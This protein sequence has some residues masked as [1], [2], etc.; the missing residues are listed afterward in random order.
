MSFWTREEHRTVFSDAEDLTYP[1]VYSPWTKWFTGC[2]VPGVMAAYAI[3]A[4]CRGVI[5]LLGHGGSMEITGEDAGFL[6]TAYLGLAAFIHFH[7]FW[8]LHRGL[9]R[10]AQPLK[11]AALL[12]ILPCFCWVIFHQTAF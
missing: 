5:L 9:E 6:A 12:V 2:L 1:P 8:N 11:I 4:W 3:F 10:F 7:C